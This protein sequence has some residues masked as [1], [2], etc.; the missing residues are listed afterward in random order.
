MSE[1]NYN[2]TGEIKEIGILDMMNGAIGERAAYELS[3]IMKNCR[4]LNTA[5]KSDRVHGGVVQRV[6][7]AVYSLRLCR[8]GAGHGGRPVQ[9]AGAALSNTANGRQ[10][11]PSCPENR[12]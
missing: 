11:R 1:K 3:R 5:A 9:R 6:G 12:R 10:R 4:D 8:Q 2:A 7:P